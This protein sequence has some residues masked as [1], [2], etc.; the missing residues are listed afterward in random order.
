MDNV[1]VELKNIV[2]KDAD[3]YIV[4]FNVYVDNFNKSVKIARDIQ[5]NLENNLK[6]QTVLKTEDQKKIAPKQ[7]L[8][9]AK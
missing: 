8:K 7:S 3:N 2:R 9:K 4:N 5:N 1:T 6:G